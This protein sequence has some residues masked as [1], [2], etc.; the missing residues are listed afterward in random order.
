MVEQEELEMLLRLEV[1]ELPVQQVE[2]EVLLL[3]EV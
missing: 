3:V 1:L 2:Q